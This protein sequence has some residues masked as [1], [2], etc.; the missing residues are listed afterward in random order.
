[1]TT[2]GL[3]TPRQTHI[4][5]VCKAHHLRYVQIQE[6]KKTPARVA[7]RRELLHRLCVIAWVDAIEAG[8]SSLRAREIHSLPRVGRSLRKHHTT[9]LYA[10][11]QFSAEHY[12]TRPK[13]TLAEMRAAYA[14]SRQGK[15]EIAA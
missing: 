5:A 9:V 13:A 14:A 1:M 10:I 6:W 3:N 11:R 7:A 12:G 8:M 15:M 4:D 2:Q